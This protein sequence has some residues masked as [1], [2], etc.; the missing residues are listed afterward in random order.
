MYSTVRVQERQASISDSVL[1]RLA[2]NAMP[3]DTTKGAK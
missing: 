1:K 2:K 3:I